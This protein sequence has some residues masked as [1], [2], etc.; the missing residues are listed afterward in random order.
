MPRTWSAEE[1]QWLRENYH[2]GTIN[3]TLAA[4]QE[5]FG[6]HHSKQATFV[7]ANHMGLHKDGH[8]KER[9]VPA[10]VHM[11]WSS[12][13]FAEHKAWMLEHDK[14][15]SV[16]RT[17]DEF[18]KEF[19]IRLNRSQVSLFRSSYGTCKRVSHGGGK[20]ALPIGTERP[21]KDGFIKVKVKMYP[22]VPQTKDNWKFKHH[23]VWEQA[24]GRPVPDDCVVLFADKDRRNFDPGN[25]VAIPRKYVGQLNNDHLPDYHDRD[26]LLACIALCDLRGAVLDAKA[27]AIR[28]CQV[29]GRE[30]V[31][32]EKTRQYRDPV[33]TCG[34][35]LAMGRKAMG[36]ADVGRGVCAVCG[37]EFV[38]GR[39]NQRRCSDCIARKPKWSVVRHKE[40]ASR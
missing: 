30:F 12:P 1:E 39:R 31:P 38:K 7:K 13:R 35:C 8:A 22:D 37:N 27:K 17:I 36:S 32:P 33:Q 21:G 15:E 29:C 14:G 25:L 16:F 24:N 40:A 20:P 3:D 34:D 4:F 5:R 6:Y 18:E 2:K 19:G 9:N 23:L 26:T 11:R 28:T 10:T